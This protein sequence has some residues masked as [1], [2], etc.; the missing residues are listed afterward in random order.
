[1]N[2]QM[3]P[4]Q[5]ITLKNGDTVALLGTAHIS[6]QSINDVELS[7]QNFAP[8][9][10]CIELDE[11]RYQN[12]KQK[13]RWDNVDLITA[14]RKG[15]GF[16]LL[17]NLIL[18]NFQKR[19]GDQLDVK[20]GAEMAK[21]I[22]LAEAS[23][24]DIALCDRKIS[25]TLK[26]AWAKSGFKARLNLFASFTD[27][28][29]SSTKLTEDELANMRKG[30]ALTEMM[31]QLGREAPSIKEVLLD[32]RDCYLAKKIFESKGSKRLAVL[33]AGHVAGVI[34]KLQELDQGQDIDL[35]AL[36]VIPKKHWASKIMTYAF[37]IIL[38][39]FFLIVGFI[40]SDWSQLGTV[41][42]KEWLFWNIT[43]AGIG[44]LVAWAH[45]LVIVV[46]MIISPISSLIPVLHAGTVAVIVQLWISKP[47]VADFEHLSQLNGWRS[48]YK[49]RISHAFLVW[50][51]AST[52]SGF[53]AIIA[54]LRMATAA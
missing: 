1:M 18:A 39:S 16:L 42:A 41:M 47:R 21:A 46:S 40:K 34:Q 28:S 11:N 30:D 17:V 4:Y 45:P 43:L 53:G 7:I 50:I 38:T 14:F 32:E 2:D 6:Q 49:N 27:Q 13:N 9:V 10:V 8:D 44:A 24:L 20:P 51:L 29:F 54:M 37:P 12:L 22:E 35:E 3:L 19:M 36:D 15:Q 48:W 33:G 5:T 31:E 23:N 25:T 52:G 26:R